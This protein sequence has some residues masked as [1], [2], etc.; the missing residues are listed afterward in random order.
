[1]C[2]QKGTHP[3]LRIALH[4]GSFLRIGKFIQ[5]Y[6]GFKGIIIILLQMKHLYQII[7]G[8]WASLVDEDEK[9]IIQE[10]YERGRKLSLLYIGNN[11]RI[12]YHR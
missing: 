7:A 3:F 4:K 5:K 10:F 6:I 2:Y 11:N 9:K 8:H 1:M 12:I